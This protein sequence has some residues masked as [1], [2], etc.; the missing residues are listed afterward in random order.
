MPT[1]DQ[2]IELCR[3]HNIHCLKSWK[4]ADIEKSLRNAGVGVS[5]GVQKNKTLDDLKKDELLKLC[6]KHKVPCAKSWRKN[7][8]VQ[9]LKNN[10]VTKPEATTSK[11]KSKTPKKSRKSRRSSKSPRKS[12]RSSKSPRKSKK[13]RSGRK[14]RKSRKSRKGKS[15]RKSKSKS[16]SLRKS[17]S[18][19]KTPTHKGGDGYDE[20][21]SKK[22]TELRKFLDAVGVKKGKPD[23]KSEMVEYLRAAEQNVRCDPEVGIHCPDDQICDASNKP[24]VCVSPSLAHKREKSGTYDTMMWGGRKII[25]TAG[26]LKVLKAKLPSS[27]R[28]SP[29]KS[30][31]AVSDD[32]LAIVDNFLEEN[33]VGEDEMDEQRVA[34]MAVVQPLIPKIYAGTVEPEDL[35]DD[36]DLGAMGVPYSSDELYNELFT[37]AMLELQIESPKAPVAQITRI[38]PIRPPSLPKKTPTPTPHRAT[39]ISPVRPPKPTP[40][41][42]PVKVSPVKPRPTPKPVEGTEITDIEE[43]LRQIQQGRG[44]E[45]G[46]LT[47]TQHA[48]LKCLGLLG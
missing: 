30:P 38:S 35:P 47:A 21:V 31:M 14:S 7:E 46:E 3:Q 16:K 39:P 48:V 25:G 42:T 27:P 20:L 24:G 22:V 17:R 23:G 28:V 18:G 8:L 36:V 34:V 41:P 19:R 26:A 29:P 11:K 13:S 45:I 37:H 1:K 4:K 10:G 43:I 33:K 32:L 5:A 2:L 15:P 9:A 6:A 12:R 40:K 44:E